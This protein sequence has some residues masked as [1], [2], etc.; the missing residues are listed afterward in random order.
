M[1]T[2]FGPSGR[3]AGRYRGSCAEA[4]AAEGEAPGLAEGEGAGFDEG[5]VAGLEG[6]AEGFVCSC[7]SAA[8]RIPAPVRPTA[9]VNQNL[10]IECLR[11]AVLALSQDHS[12]SAGIAD[13]S[14]ATSCGNDFRGRCRCRSRGS[15]VLQRNATEVAPG[16]S[17]LAASR[18]AQTVPKSAIVAAARERRWELGAAFGA[19]T[20]N[21]RSEGHYFDPLPANAAAPRKAK[22][23]ADDK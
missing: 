20:A 2:E 4:G 1:T 11:N 14:R 17:A 3:S 12:S 8:E 22:R 7:T 18:C 13:P 9:R 23:A 16:S 5:A 15:T 19:I 21:Y 6:V 10:N